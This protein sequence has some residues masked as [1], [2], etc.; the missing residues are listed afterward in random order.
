MGFLYN[1]IPAVVNNG[2]IVSE[3]GQWR[4]CLVVDNQ[5]FG[6]LAR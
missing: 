4:E 6:F 5:L 2:H 1:F 3:N